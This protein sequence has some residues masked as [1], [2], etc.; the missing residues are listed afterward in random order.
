M[1]RYGQALGLAYQIV[2]DL[3][4]FEDDAETLG[5]PTDSDEN[6]GR[7]TYPTVA[8]VNRAR[9]RVGALVREAGEA[10]AGLGA[11]AAVLRGLG[12]FVLQRSA[13]PTTKSSS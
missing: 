5:R 7:R 10:I 13:R 1:T 12:E 2:D 3:L 11:G 8:G 9:E 4:A 6:R